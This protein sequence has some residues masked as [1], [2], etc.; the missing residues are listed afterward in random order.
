[1][2]GIAKSHNLATK[3]PQGHSVNSITWKLVRNAD[4][5]APLKTTETESLRTPERRHNSLEF[6]QVLQEILRHLAKD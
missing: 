4:P 5:L 3:Q 2:H 1:V 6:F